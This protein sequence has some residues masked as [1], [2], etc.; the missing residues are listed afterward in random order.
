[1]ADC[2]QCG[3]KVPDNLRFCGFCGIE[4]ATGKEA[5]T[6]RWLAYLRTLISIN[7]KAASMADTRMIAFGT[8]AIGSLLALITNLPP[9]S[10]AGSIVAVLA[11]M[12]LIFGSRFLWNSLSSIQSANARH[13]IFRSAYELGLNGR[14]STSKDFSGFMELMR[15][16][17]RR[18]LEYEIK[19]GHEYAMEMFP[20]AKVVSPREMPPQN[21]PG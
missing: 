11:S 4:L 2:P 19:R 18:H 1:M 21:P 15:E 20:E 6:E 8:L 7:T 12:G 10:A 13:H 3:K 16:R 5:M 9:T 14:L 17:L